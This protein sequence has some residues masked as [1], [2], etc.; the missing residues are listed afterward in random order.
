MN[1]KK[2]YH[3]LIAK[4]RS[5]NR[6]KLAKEH[7]DYIYYENHHIIPK[8]I[9]SGFDVPENLILLTA[10]EHYIAH[11]LLTYIYPDTKEIFYALHLMTFMNKSKY[12]LSNRDYEYIRHAISNIPYSKERREKI[13]NA[14]SGK[15]NGMY[16]KTIK[17]VWKEKY[18]SK[19]A[20][21]KWEEY[22]NNFR[23]GKNNPN[24]GNTHTAVQKRKWSKERKGRKLTE[25]WKLNIKKTHPN[26][27]KEKH[28]N[29]GKIWIS[30]IDTQERKLIEKEKLNNYLEN[31]WVKGRKKF[32]V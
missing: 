8:C 29:W 25:E 5:E 11:K 15:N 2:I 18:S 9:K 4:A 21:Q 31:G 13:S 7:Q 22:L 6:A 32:K 17:D 3:D 19:I 16:G 20:N 27:K 14:S 28:N 12:I 26:Y 23:R 24:F 10:R 30:N 1:Y